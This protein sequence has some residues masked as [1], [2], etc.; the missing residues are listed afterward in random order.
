MESKLEIKH[1]APYLPHGIQ[2]KLEFLEDCEL[3]WYY[4]DKEIFTLEGM[5][6]DW[7]NSSNI[8]SINPLLLPLS[9][10]TDPQWIEVIRA[11]Y[12][13]HERQSV[14]NIIRHSSA[15]EIDMFLKVTTYDF[16]NRQFESG[17]YKFNQLAA[18]EELYKLHG[19]VFGLIDKGLAIDKTLI[20]A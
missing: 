20:P 9:E 16:N 8:T 12:D 4:E 18:F 13:G 3:P 2:V 10:F 14:P 1:L 17:C 7:Y 11:G 19:D 15:I 5:M 6:L